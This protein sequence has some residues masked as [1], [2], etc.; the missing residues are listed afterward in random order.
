MHSHLQKKCKAKLTV[1]IYL[2]GTA[3]VVSASLVSVNRRSVDV[4]VTSSCSHHAL[5]MHSPRTHHA[6]IMHSPC[7]RH[8]VI[9]QSLCSHRAVT[10]QS[11]CPPHAVPSLAVS[12]L[13]VKDWTSVIKFL[14]VLSGGEVHSPRDMKLQCHVLP[15]GRGA[16]GHLWRAEAGCGG[17]VHANAL[18]GS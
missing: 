12:V 11:S 6:V 15:V 13:V 14:G 9:M 8:A 16:E 3:L 4:K 1:C 10:M 5:I 18:S 7:S 2:V 17:H